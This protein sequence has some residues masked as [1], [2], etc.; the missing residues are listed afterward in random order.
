MENC[1]LFLLRGFKPDGRA[2]VSA[3]FNKELRS[4]RDT[5]NGLQSFEAKL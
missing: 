3:N 4:F 2:A 1:A 5:N